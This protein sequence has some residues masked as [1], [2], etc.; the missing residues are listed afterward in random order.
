MLCG[1]WGLAGNFGCDDRFGT[2]SRIWVV[3]GE[4]RTEFGTTLNLC[5]KSI[6]VDDTLMAWVFSAFLYFAWAGGFGSSL[7]QKSR[8]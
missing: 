8:N 5:L 6:K 3:M 7:N 4:C 1:I 2:K